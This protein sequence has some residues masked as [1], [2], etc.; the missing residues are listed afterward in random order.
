VVPHCH[1]FCGTGT[2][3]VAAL[4]DGGNSVAVDTNCT[5]FHELNSR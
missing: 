1:P 2:T 5:N 4:K 3:I